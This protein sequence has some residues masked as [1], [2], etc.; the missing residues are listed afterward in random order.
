MEEVL[1]YLKRPK[2]YESDSDETDEEEEEEIVMA[3][4]A[5]TVSGRDHKSGYTKQ[6]G[7]VFTE[8]D[9]RTSYQGADFKRLF[10]F[11]LTQIIAL[12]TVLQVPPMLTL[13]SGHRITGL[14]GNK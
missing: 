13:Q 14:H 10:R 8:A 5:A 1:P 2:C 9:L 3:A 6:R 11:T 7:P 12:L 4:A